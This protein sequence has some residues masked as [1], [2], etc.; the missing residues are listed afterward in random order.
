MFVTEDALSYVLRRRVL[1]SRA[2]TEVALYPVILRL[3]PARPV[4]NQSIPHIAKRPDGRV[5]AKGVLRRFT[6]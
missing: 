4:Q 2:S 5:A 3:R 1:E 6:R